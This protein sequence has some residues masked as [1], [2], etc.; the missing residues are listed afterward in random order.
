MRINANEA[1]RVA[2]RCRAWLDGAEVTTHCF[3]ADTDLSRVGLYKTDEHGHITRDPES[4]G[5]IQEWRYGTV[6]LEVDGAH[7]VSQPAPQRIAP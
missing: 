7:F 2:R 3:E 4:D 6:E 1:P 5:P